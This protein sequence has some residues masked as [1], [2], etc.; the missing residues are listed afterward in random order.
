[1]LPRPRHERAGTRG[2]GRQV[3]RK[4]GGTCPSLTLRVL[5]ADDHALVRAG[6]RALLKAMP[7]VEVVA[8]AANGREALDLIQTHRPDVVFMD[9]AMP[10]LN[11]L[12]ALVRV[13]ERFPDVDVIILSMHADEEH[14][15]HSLRAGAKGYLLKN[16]DAAE[17]DLALAALR[18]REIYLSPATNKFLI[19]DYL[20]RMSRPAGPS[21]R[22]TSR[23]R[24]VLQ[25]I[26]EGSTSK[27]I[28]RQLDLSV[29][30]VATHRMQLMERLNLHDIAG[31]V[32]YAVGKGLVAPE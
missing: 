8:E 5:L 21:E 22:L 13:S 26:A 9:I 15:L 32:L 20:G 7:G 31:L 2:H 3:K 16:A 23:Q 30:T 18:R 6:F 14:V 25:L 19:T 24:E 27:E 1:M 4:D 28:A 10:V 17:L 11:G 29:K 12:E